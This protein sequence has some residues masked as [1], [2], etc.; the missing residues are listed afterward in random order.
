MKTDRNS[1][2]SVLFKSHESHSPEDILAA[3]GATA[4]GKKSEK[5]NE[6]I[7][8]ALTNVPAAEPFSDQE[9]EDLLVQLESDK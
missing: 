1:V 7:I 6:S 9:W 5:N 8:S 4:F 3:G 2:H